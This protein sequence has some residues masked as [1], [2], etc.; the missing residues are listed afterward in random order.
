MRFHVTLKR[1]LF[2]TKAN[3]ESHKNRHIP[4]SGVKDSSD[5]PSLALAYDLA[6][7]KIRFQLNLVNSLDAKTNLIIVTATG[8]ISA[9][10]A[11][12]SL[13]LPSHSYASC[14]ILLPNSIYLFIHHLPL[15][16]KRTLPSLPLLIIYLLTMFSAYHAYRG[17][18][19]DDVP[20][21]YHIYNTCLSESE[22]Y[23][24][25]VLLRAML[26]ASKENRN[27]LKIKT[28]YIDHALAWLLI[29]SVILVCFLLFQ[30]MC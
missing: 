11:L 6:Y 24:K 14:S 2:S 27:V 29:E 25:A 9:A 19:Y 4:T 26:E 23:T 12:Q 30:F 22:Q 3:K 10:L 1:P 17:R 21:L 7:N 16:M 13:L 5:Y 8:L 28:R 20:D 18:V 15:L